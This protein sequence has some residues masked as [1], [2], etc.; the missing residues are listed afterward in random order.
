MALSVLPA[1]KNQ[2]KTEYR[3]YIG[4]RKSVCWTQQKNN[5]DEVQRTPRAR[6]ADQ[7]ENSAVA[8]K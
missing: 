3:V 6:S 4:L 1:F 7:P 5:R 8:R 2:A